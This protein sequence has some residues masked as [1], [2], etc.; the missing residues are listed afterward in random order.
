MNT[1]NNIKEGKENKEHKGKVENRNTVTVSQTY[2][3]FG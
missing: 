2:Q 1:I 3:Y